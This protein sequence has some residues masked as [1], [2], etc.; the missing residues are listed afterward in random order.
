MIAAI[1]LPFLHSDIDTRNVNFFFIGDGYII[2]AWF[3]KIFV[4]ISFT[5]E[6]MQ[7]KIF[8]LNKICISGNT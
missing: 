6:K 4:K 8:I 3:M 7:S 1:A 2:A 5:T